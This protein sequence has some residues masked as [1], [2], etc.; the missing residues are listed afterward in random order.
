SIVPVE[1]KSGYAPREP[2]DGHVL[3]LAAYCLLVEEAYGIRPSHGIL[4]Y[5]DSAFAVDFSYELERDLL[6]LLEVM[7]DDALSEEVFR[8]H[9]DPAR[10]SSCGLLT[11]CQQSLV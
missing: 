5:R 3:Q 1:V 11:Y 6:D 10:C 8:D 4:Q 2:Y 9:D 7:R